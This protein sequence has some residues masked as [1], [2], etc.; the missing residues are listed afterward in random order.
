M[1][2]TIFRRPPR[3]QPPELPQGTVALEP[4][5]ELTE[6]VSGG[7]GAAMTYL[8]M[9]A[10]G[11]AMAF[12]V[13]G[14]GSSPI[15]IVAGVLYAASMAGMMVG[16]IGR[17]AGE[18]KRKLNAERRDYARY[19]T[20][21]RKQVRRAAGQQRDA[22]TWRHPAPD[23]LWSLAMTPRLW[24]RRAADGDFGE[25]RIGTGVQRLT[26]RLVPPET[27]PVEDLEP[28][29]AGALRRFIRTHSTVNGLPV[30]VSLRG[31]G[32]LVLQ[33]DPAAA[34]GLTRAMVAQAVVA[35]APDELRVVVC[36][37]PDR[38]GEWD[39]VKWLPHALHPVR[40]DA[41]GPVR[42][43]SH[44]M[45]E[46]EE[47]VPELQERGRFTGEGGAVP[48]IVVV[49]D[50][51]VDLG[52]SNLATSEVEGVTVVE[53][54]RTQAQRAARSQALVL[55]LDPSTMTRITHDRLG[56]EVRQVLG[57]PD[58]LERGAAEGL[59]RLLAP[60]RTNA[61]AESE[62]VLSMDRGL[63]QLMGLG[64]ARRLDVATTW[65]PR[66]PRDRLRAPIGVGEAGELIELDIKEAAQNGMGPHG[67][68]VGATG[69]GKS[70]LLRTLVL[71]LAVKNSSEALNFVLVDFKGGATFA[72]LE[73]L[74]HT[75]A[76]ITNLADDLAMVDRM[77]DAIDGELNRR[78]ELLRDAGNYA[79]LKDY[80]E[81]R[82][83]GAALPPVPTLFIVVDEFSELL[84]AQPDFIDLFIA[85]G[86]IGRSLGVHLLLASQRLEEGRLRGL[87]T[88][89]SYRIGLRTFSALESRVVLGE[90]VAYELPSAPG[91]GY[92][93]VDTSTMQRFK[94]AYVS[95]PYLGTRVADTAAIELATRRVV[96]FTAGYVAP[97]ETSV[98]PVVAEPAPDENPESVLEV[99][100][101]QLAGRGV[102]AH[103]VWL[104]PLD[105]SVSLGQLL[106]GLRP[107]PAYGLHPVGWPGR[108]R[109]QVPVGLVDM[110]YYQ[111]RDPL[112]FDLSGAGGHIVVVGGPQSGKSTVVRDLI[113]GLA[114]THTPL[115]TQFYCIDL[116]GGTLNSLEGLPHVGSVAGRLAG[117]SV[118][119]ILAEM[120]SLLAD[121]EQMF[122]A[123][124][125]DSMATYRRMKARG[126]I[127]DD[128]YGD[129]FL[130]V[131][132]WGSI[133][134]D[135]EELEQQIT[136]LAA[137]GLSYG[138]HILITAQRWMELRPALRDLIGTRIELRLGDP[139]ES[140]VDRRAAA[141]V[142]K[143]VPG[144]G[145][146]AAKLH[147]LSVLPRIDGGTEPETLVA[148]V[149]DLVEKVRAAWH[150]P[151]APRVRLLPADLP[152]SALP[153]LTGGPRAAA[154]ASGEG[155]PIGIDED[156]LA[157]VYL[158]V[159]Q[160]PH[161]VIFGDTR[162]GKSN[163]LRV[164][165]QQIIERYSPESAKIIVL[166]YR[167]EL[168]D[169]AQAPHMLAYGFA[170]PQAPDIVN[171]TVAGLQKR[172]PPANLTP[173]QLRDR[174][175][176]SGP[177]LFVIVDDYDMV[178]TGSS[179]PLLPFLD[180]A[181][182]GRDIGLHLILARA[183]GGAG[184]SM[185][186]PLV[187]KLRETG[188]PAVIL[189][190][191]KDEGN[192]FHGV[193]P[194][195][196]PPGR[197]RLATRQ[198]VKLIQTA[199]LPPTAAN[200]PTGPIPISDVR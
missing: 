53:L 56:A 94:A 157:P 160:D 120:R 194:E 39:W 102:P 177:E 61:G 109:L 128:P 19:L 97:D 63:L 67:L 54:A 99:V 195:P 52:T 101:S 169:L 118:R 95:G 68:V 188:S 129:V 80:E 156:D 187:Q 199:K 1:G 179:N 36:A 121:R 171:N 73:D 30:S 57:T 66:P 154:R 8:P 140:D 147:F 38:L 20:Q 59:A 103:Q 14:Q 132:G 158:N 134:S 148:G 190:G 110:P 49:I 182:L 131:D 162:S 161:L 164:I 41:A 21:V 70:E 32:R 89:L 100:V 186:E 111:R 126:E 15:T 167:H 58:R 37:N 71:G 180:L 119:R 35:H 29:S 5:P 92:L 86:R 91:H 116:G 74:P 149:A 143:S 10:G 60:L 178:A 163:L 200:T 173:Q 78:Q 135:F 153:Q 137:R 141:N 31:F 72:R 17:G 145:I 123:L 55:E 51:D 122:D 43:F 75:A 98:R 34:R 185:F 136:E 24:E 198:G 166:D 127:P 193:R 181:P 79:N 139:T 28:L 45:S 191:A 40:T 115:E 96:P 62:D 87:E 2:I 125:I 77:R 151:E 18:K 44:R 9:L 176:W 124:R 184:R 13:V 159:A 7:L 83:K 107:D 130:V 90:P 183:M 117:A 33:G 104:P 189:S 26:V 3:I 168:I 81:A 105:E 170:S 42:L 82:N 23:A 150:G 142:P 155:L 22:L 27:K 175:W 88:Y 174:S 50:G 133:R 192:L 4:P 76:V 113:A 84:S 16:Q 12:L 93:K 114:L 152:Y 65:Q 48:Q 69:S 144:R 108:G 85:I 106:P 165:T 196:L 138:L 146:T 197:A 6:T 172:L 112:W 64:D 47:L 46:L 11:G 25:V